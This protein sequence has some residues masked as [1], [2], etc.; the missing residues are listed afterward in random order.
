MEKWL[1]LLQHIYGSHEFP[2]NNIFKRCEHGNI[3][4]EWLTP[5]SSSY[6]G[7]SRRNY[8]YLI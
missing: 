3:D 6:I 7:L 5:T 2:N 4:R 1:S 8:L